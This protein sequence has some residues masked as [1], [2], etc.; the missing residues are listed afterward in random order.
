M[1]CRNCTRDAIHWR[2]FDPIR[3][4]RVH[5]T[6]PTCSAACLETWGDCMVDPNE[7]EIA[8][9][10]AASQRGGEFID[11][12][13]SRTDMARWSTAEWQQFVEAVCTGYVDA[14]VN[15]QA[16]ALSALSKIQNAA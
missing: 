15:R 7:A 12:L 4:L 14:L 3:S 11:S 6:L 10:E 16:E 2:W 8:A 9:M 5:L 1:K 13:G